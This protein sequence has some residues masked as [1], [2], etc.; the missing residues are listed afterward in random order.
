M[1]TSISLYVR[2]NSINNYLTCTNKI[3]QN[4]RR[5]NLYNLIYVSPN[6]IQYKNKLFP[7]FV[8]QL[9]LANTM[10]LVP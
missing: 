5:T 3:L 8:P 9:M 4:Q 1:S 6:E 7:N 10:S 2:N